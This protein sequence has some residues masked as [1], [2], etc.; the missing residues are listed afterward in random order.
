MSVPRGWR[1]LVRVFALLALATTASSSAAGAPRAP[2][3]ASRSSR[4]DEDGPEPSALSA[5]LAT[6]GNLVP[7]FTYTAKPETLLKIRKR[8]RP[9]MTELV[10]GG[11]FDPRHNIW[12]FHTDWTEQLLGGNLG[13]HGPELQWSKSL[14]FPGIADVA[15]R[16]KFIASLDLRTI[17]T[18]T[19]MEV[20]LRRASVFQRGLQLERKVPL[21]GADGHFKLGLVGAVEFPETIGLSG[22][23]SG[24]NATEVNIGLH[25]KRVD[26]LVDF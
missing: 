4:A 20:S 19:A 25:L 11:D 13:L 12:T 21:D 9:L 7:R 23:S 16:V 14:F 6:L 3:G 24:L 5:T 15:T 18:R 1:Q 8:F 26:L 22:T 2:R 10:V 17:E